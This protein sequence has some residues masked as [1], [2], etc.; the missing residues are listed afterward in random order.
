MDSLHVHL[1]DL[2]TTVKRHFWQRY[3][4]L[5]L[6]VAIV[7]VVLAYILAHRGGP[8]ASAQVTVASVKSESIA[9]QLFTTGTVATIHEASVFAPSNVG[10]SPTVNV[11]VGDTVLQGQVVATF[12]N[13][14]QSTQ[15]SVALAA[16]HIQYAMWQEDKQL[17]VQADRQ[18]VPHSSAAYVQ[19]LEQAQSA[20]L[21]YQNALV[22]VESARASQ[23]S[24]ELLSPIAGTVTAVN[25]P[26]SQNALTGPLVVID[27][28]KDLYV[29]AS[30][31]QMDST[32]VGSGLPVTITSDAWP[33]HSW[34]G[35][36]SRVAPMAVVLANAATN[37]SAMVPIEVNVSKSFPVHL[38]FSVNLT[39][40]SKT[41]HGLAIP[42][43]A[44]VETGSGSQVW[45]VHGNQVHL[46]TITLGIT[47]NNIVQVTSGLH[48]GDRVVL[49][50]SSNLYSGEEVKVS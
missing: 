36:I 13:Q 3:A 20:Q 17:L 46:H 39:I 29:S 30:L 22:Q 23:A 4:W 21:Q 2:T 10:V 50:P 26:G 31:S 42:Y 48:K 9:Q 1:E 27:D 49:N 33:G 8:Q 37:S 24:S 14:Q 35:T 18:H 16:K 28:L 6:L 38:G 34:R 41:V 5:F 11:A 25:P 47:G 44:L 12:P 40:N 32:T 43:S 19:L 45:V 15:L 7:I